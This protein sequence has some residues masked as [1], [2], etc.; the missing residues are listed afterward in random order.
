MLQ[1]ETFE[2]GP[3]IIYPHLRRQEACDIM[4]PVKVIY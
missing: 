4:K 1:Y 2:K 3:E